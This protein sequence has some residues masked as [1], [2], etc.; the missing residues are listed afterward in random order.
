MGFQW[1]FS[2]RD[3]MDQMVDGIA[4]M[5]IRFFIVSN[6]NRCFK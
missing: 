1:G 6:F 5:F 2:I 3:T 4:M